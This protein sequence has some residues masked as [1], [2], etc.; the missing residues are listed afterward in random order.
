MFD[1]L[2]GNKLVASSLLLCGVGT[3]VVPFCKSVVVLGV[4]VSVQGLAMGI[5]DTGGNGK[6]KS[7][8]LSPLVF[9]LSFFLSLPVMLVWLH[10]D[11]VAPYMQLIHFAFGVGAF[12]SPLLID[13]AKEHLG[14]FHWALWIMGILFFGIGIVLCFVQ[15]Q[16][17]REKLDQDGK[18][19]KLTRLEASFSVSCLLRSQ[20]S[21]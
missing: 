15:S 11:G 21:S 4:A 3:V 17:P 1:K 16:K 5:L 12:L 13:V 9:H 8:G 10:G 6:G 2:P 18:K 14:S 19:V 20:G 7:R